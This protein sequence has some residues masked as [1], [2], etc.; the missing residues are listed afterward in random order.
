[1]NNKNTKAFSYVLFDPT[2]DKTDI[3]YQ[4]LKQ[5]H[6]DQN[7]KIHLFHN[8]DLLISS[9]HLFNEPSIFLL[10]MSIKEDALYAYHQIHQHFSNSAIIY[11][12]DTIE[13]VFDI[14]ET[15]FCYFIHFERW[16][17]S[18][19]PA[20][21][22]AYH[23]IS[24]YNNKLIIHMKDKTVFI[25]EE[26]I[27]Y[28]ERVKRTTYIYADEQYHDSRNLETLLSQLNLH[29]VQCHRSFAV[30]LDKVKE[31]HRDK[32]VLQNGQII[33]ISRPYTKEIKAIIHQYADNQKL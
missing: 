2:L 32:F 31:Y 6:Y 17:A 20:L 29:F 30:N 22:K 3:V 5:F 25:P 27:D 24:K 9:F 8:L 14:L 16:D 26:E 15:D 7:L 10:D 18:L 33:P 12:S 4:S 13:S 11:I 1:M 21:K 23:Y 19:I 28:L